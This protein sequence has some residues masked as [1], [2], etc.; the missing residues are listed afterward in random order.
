[1][2]PSSLKR[3]VKQ[4]IKTKCRA[5]SLTFIALPVFKQQQ[6]VMYIDIIVC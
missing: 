4:T 6:I 5:F 3:T 2:K 1:M